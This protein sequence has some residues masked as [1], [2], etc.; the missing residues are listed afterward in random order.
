MTDDTD[1]DRRSRA[2]RRVRSP[3]PD[4]VP[5]PVAPEDDLSAAQ[6]TLAPDGTVYVVPSGMHERFR[7]AVLGDAGADRDPKVALALHG[8][9]SLHSDGMTD[10]IYVD[11]PDRFTDA[12]TV[13]R[14]ASAHDAGSVAV[15]R[16]PSG[17]RIQSR[18][19]GSL[20]LPDPADGQAGDG[21]TDSDSDS[22]TD[23]DSDSD[24]GSASR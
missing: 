7:Q 12:A 1:D 2:E 13:R 14:F 11:A 22:G 5:F 4:E 18:P 6:V 17:D 8:Y 10:R 3:P 19:P 16:H 15:V 23:S 9:A 24:T 20:R 21:V